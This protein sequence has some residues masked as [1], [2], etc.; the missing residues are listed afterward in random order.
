MGNP[1]LKFIH[2]PAPADPSVYLGTEEGDRLRN[3]SAAVQT[4][5][6]E[7]WSSKK[8]QGISLNQPVSGIEIPEEL[9]GFTA[10]LTRMHH[11]E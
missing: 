11:L 5:N 8:E 7:T 9:L 10:I 4:F 2:S 3:L 6:G 1:Q